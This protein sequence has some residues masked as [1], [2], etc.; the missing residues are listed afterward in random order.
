MENSYFIYTDQGADLEIERFHICT[1]EFKNNSAFIEFGCEV[2]SRSI[3][4]KASIQFELFIP[5]FKESCTIKDFYDKLKESQNSRF[6]FNDSITQSTFLDG[7]RNVS[8]VIHKFSD[9]D[10][11]CILPIQLKEN[12]EKNVISL[13]VNLELY[14]RFYDEKEE[15]PNIYFRFAVTPKNGLIATRKNGITKS[16][17]LYD[18]KLNQRRNIPESLIDEIIFK[19]L[20]PVAKC[21]CFN[22]I[23]NSYDLVFFDSSTLKNV[24]TLEYKSFKKYINDD[25][26]KEDDLIV[27]FNKKERLDAYAFFSIFSKEHIGADQFALALLISLVSGILLFIPSYKISLGQDITYYE[28]WPKMPA[29]FWVVVGLVFIELIYFI[30]RKF[31][32]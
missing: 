5:W 6:I 27:V 30:W 23:P 31:K 19:D 13:S 24:R 8:G 22:I 12:Y 18:I 17:I 11:L 26:L 7:G 28:L 1:W 32:K 21:F 25:R 29:L 3:F 15:R 20:C 9:R 10:E 4:D 2:T 16:T 14:N